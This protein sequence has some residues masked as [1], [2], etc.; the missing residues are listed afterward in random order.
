MEEKL[1]IIKE[2]ILKHIPAKYIYLFGSHAYGVPKED[3][4]ID[5]YVV[6]PDDFV[7]DM[8][9]HG[10]ICRDLANIEIYEI[11]LHIATESIFN[12]YR[13][14]SRFEGTIYEK[15]NMLHADK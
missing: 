13:S 8:F 9:L 10:T 12:K 6:T 7:E 3:S 1:E 4:D 11:D 15:G 5:I 14:L 2:T